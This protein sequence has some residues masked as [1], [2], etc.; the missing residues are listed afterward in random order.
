MYNKCLK[1]Q[2]LVLILWIQSTNFLISPCRCEK[3]RIEVT[4]SSDGPAGT[5]GFKAPV[6]GP[7]MGGGV[8]S[9]QGVNGQPWEILLISGYFQSHQF[10]LLLLLV[11]KAIQSGSIYLCGTIWILPGTNVIGIMQACI[12]IKFY[13]FNSEL[14]FIWVKYARTERKTENKSISMHGYSSSQAL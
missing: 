9:F 14:I 10:L 4:Q 6:K 3:R 7:F 13:T 1:F 12:Y 8:L 5:V 2:S 11:I